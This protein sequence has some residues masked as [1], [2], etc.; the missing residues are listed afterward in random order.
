MR[1]QGTPATETG[2]DDPRNAVDPLLLQLLR[3]ARRIESSMAGELAA[4]GV[5][6]EQWRLLSVL[7]GPDGTRP[8]GHTMTEVAQAAVL[9]P[10]STTRGMDRLVSLGLVYRRPDPLDRRRVLVFLSARGVRE[11]ASARRAEAAAEKEFADAIGTRG[12]V[13]RIDSTHQREADRRI[14]SPAGP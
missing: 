8:T 6:A 10:A 13:G 14:D 5:S 12:Y 9:P 4:L 7:A 11:I 2:Q 3:A 1:G